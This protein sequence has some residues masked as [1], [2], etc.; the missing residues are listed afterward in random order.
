MKP[1]GTSG[2][3]V[4]ASATDCFSKI[5]PLD[6]IFIIC[7]LLYDK[8]YQVRQEGPLALYRGM[9]GLALFSVPRFALLWYFLNLTSRNQCLLL[10]AE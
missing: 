6:T 7:C 5:V 10:C 1:V 9:S 4:Y 3:M 2:G 8:S